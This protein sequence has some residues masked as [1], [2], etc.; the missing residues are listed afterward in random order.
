MRP[1]AIGIM[2]VPLALLLI[3]CEGPNACLVGQELTAGQSCNVRLA[4]MDIDFEVRDDGCVGQST[5]DAL[6]AGPA[7]GQEVW[8]EFGLMSTEAMTVKTES[9]NSNFNV[10]FDNIAT[11]T[12]RVQAGVVQVS[13]EL[14]TVVEETEDQTTTTTLK[15]PCFSGSLALGD[16]FKASQVTETSDIWHVDKAP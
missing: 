2:C 3:G 6:E 13:G 1:G 4:G 14:L 5:L 7:G 10:T 11:K 15:N 9:A 8:V 16:Q 12:I